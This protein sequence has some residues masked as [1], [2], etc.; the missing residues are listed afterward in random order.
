MNAPDDA[1]ARLFKP[2][3]FDSGLYILLLLVLAWL[4][5]YGVERLFPWLATVVPGRLRRYIL[6]AIPQVRLAVI[7][8]TLLTVVPLVIEPT[9]QNM[10]VVVGTAGLALGFAFKDY[11]SSLIA[12]VVAI[13]ERPYRPGDWVR[14][15][16]AYGEVQ[17]VGLRALRLLT[18]DDTVVTIP[19]SRIWTGNIFNDNDGARSLQ[20]VADFHLH[21]RHD[22]A[23]V[24]QKLEDVALTSAY[25]AVGR[26]VAV[27]LAE[28]PWG[29]HYRLK[30][31]PIDARD[32]FAFKSDLTLRGRAA[33]ARL[34]AEPVC[35][36]TGLPAHP[37][38]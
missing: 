22:A 31:Y 28:T 15:G 37:A 10:M 17:S 27:V 2:V 24:R 21:P 35:L 30:A 33:L 36:P 4:L 7:V 5:V 23:A 9:P 26:P 18:P 16:D 11:G 1:A 38:A 20:C 3:D 25:L 12:G 13:Y 29:T 34:G 6:P 14:L 19:H 32:Q 8:G